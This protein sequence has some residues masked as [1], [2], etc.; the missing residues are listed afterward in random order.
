MISAFLCIFL[1]DLFDYSAAVGA[2][3]TLAIYS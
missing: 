1:I 3:Y 2:V